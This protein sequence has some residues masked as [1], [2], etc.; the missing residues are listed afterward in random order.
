MYGEHVAGLFNYF[1]Q[2]YSVNSTST[3]PLVINTH[4]W[5]KGDSNSLHLVLVT[6]QTLSRPKF[7]SVSFTVWKELLISLLSF[8]AGIGYDVVVDILNSTYPTHVVQVLANSVKKN[9]PRNKFW[10]ETSTAQTIYVES[11]VEKLPM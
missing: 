11:A 6:C 4:G 1:R 3:I 2:K 7:L 5:V 9:L 8:L 10:D